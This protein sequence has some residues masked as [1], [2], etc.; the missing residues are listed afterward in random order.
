M[1]K[2][3]ACVPVLVVLGCSAAP[4]AGQSAIPDDGSQAVLDA[5]DASSARHADLARELWKLAEV[6][7]QEEKSAKLLASELEKAGFTVE[8]GVAGMPTAFVASFGSG[9][10]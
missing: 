4:T 6:G 5:L 8:R 9:K 2:L 3:H 7:Y 1:T 10:P